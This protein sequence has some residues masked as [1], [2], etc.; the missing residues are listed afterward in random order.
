MAITRRKQLTDLLDGYPGRDELIDWIR[1]KGSPEWTDYLDEI[2][3]SRRETSE[4][5]DAD[6][7]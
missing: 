2:E 1:Q 4:P 6:K 3:P 7:Q 5:G